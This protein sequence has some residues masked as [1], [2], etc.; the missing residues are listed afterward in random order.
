MTVEGSCLALAFYLCSDVRC[1]YVLRTKCKVSLQPRTNV[2]YWVRS[3]SSRSR[4]GYRY[5]WLIIT[6]QTR[7]GRFCTL[8]QYTSY[9]HSTADGYAHCILNCTAC[10]YGPRPG[11]SSNSLIAEHAGIPRQDVDLNT[12]TLTARCI[13]G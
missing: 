3:T 4:E 8:T 6:E 13:C 1:T 11:I 10:W 12:P 5:W 7:G 2:L 9:R